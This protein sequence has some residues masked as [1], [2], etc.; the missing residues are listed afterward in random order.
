MARNIAFNVAARGVLIVLSIAI[1]PVL[2]RRLGTDQYGIYALATGLGAGLTNILALGLIPGVV[3]LLSR[4][5]AR[6]TTA[7]TER[8]VGTGFTLFAVIGVVSA[9]ILSLL[10]PLLVTRVLRI[11]VGLQGVAAMAL[12][13]SAI[14]L[15]FNLVFAVFNAVPYALQRYD[16]IAGRLVGLTILST[17]ATVVY[18]LF[19]PDL[20]G[21]IAIQV[22]GGMAGLLL[23]FLVSRREL[24]GVSLLPGFDGPTFAR[25]ARFTAFK[26]VGDLALVF[27]SRFDQFAVGSLLNIGAVGLY[28]IPANTCQRILQLLYEVAAPLF[29]R[30][31]T[32]EDEQARRRLL[33]RGTRLVALIAALLTVVL[34]VLAEPILRIWIGGSQGVE[35]ARGASLAFRLLSLAIFVQAVA[36][37]AGFYCEAIQRPVV[38]NSFVVLGAIVQ[39]PAILFLVPRYGIT[40]AAAGV[41]IA[42][43]VQTVPF[44]LLFADRVARVGSGRLLREAVLWPSIS[45]AVAGIAGSPLER[46]ATGPLG[47]LAVAV[48]MA[49]VYAAMAA[50]TGAVRAGDL[51]Q[52]QRVLPVRLESIPGH[53]L[54]LRLL[55]P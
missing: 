2:V 1:T 6:G 23:Y 12:W 5:I 41:L 46:F 51:L 24:K 8:I 33:L 27:S 22:V 36:A 4:S 26:S 34:L 18:V 44:L 55:R 53:R 43:L 37:V 48:A 14:G 16:I 7:E 21:V 47:L 3:A 38:N 42:G 10:V 45:A 15:G 25:L 31:S 9:V 54:L 32:V 50:V 49:A 39:V 35:V 20:I 28:A 40:G 11:P 17:G 29:P 30:I 52:V 13:L 19:D